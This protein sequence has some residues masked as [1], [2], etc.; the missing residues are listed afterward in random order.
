MVG[1][2]F[3]H[4]YREGSLSVPPARDIQTTT[5]P[6][7]GAAMVDVKLDVPGQYMLVD[8]ALSRAARGLSAALKV[9]GPSNPDVYADSGAS[10]S[11][12]AMK[13]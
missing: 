2:I 1:E 5:V 6:P 10:S 11:A 12:H 3:D 7:G 9:M 4:V 13:H 8:H